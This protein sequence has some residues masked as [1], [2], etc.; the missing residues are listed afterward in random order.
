MLSAAC[1]AAIRPFG[2]ARLPV[3]APQLF[4][5]GETRRADVAEAVR[6]AL[7]TAGYRET[8]DAP[9]RVEI[10]FA[11]RPPGVAVAGTAGMQLLSPPAPGALGLCHREAY[12][13]TVAMIDRASGTVLRRSG[14][15]T[16][17]CRGKEGEALPLLAR[18]AISPAP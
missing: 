6:G 17:R 10:T 5:L 12:V 11:V 8:A 4:S 14:A 16:A 7:R 15:I 3:A 13:L 1:A 18:A 9:L 2:A